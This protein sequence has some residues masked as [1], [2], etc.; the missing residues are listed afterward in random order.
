MGTYYRV[1]FN[2]NAE[3][4]TTGNNHPSWTLNLKWGNAQS[5]QP[6]ISTNQSSTNTTNLGK[7]YVYKYTDDLSKNGTKFAY[8][9]NNDVNINGQTFASG[10]HIQGE[11][12]YKGQYLD[13]NKE[14]VAGIS[15]V[16]NRVWTPNNGV[17]VNQNWQNNMGFQVAM[18]GA[19]D[20]KQDTGYDFDCQVQ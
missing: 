3:T 17:I 1:V 10:L 11:Y 18:S 7:V 2:S 9:P 5:Q 16:A 6:S 19:T 8:T 4:V 13:A 15:W 12:V 20:S 14:T